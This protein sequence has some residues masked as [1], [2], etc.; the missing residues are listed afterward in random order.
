[1]WGDQLHSDSLQFG[2]KRGCG[3]S[4]ATWLVQ[5]VL[6]HFLR[7]GSK[8]IAVV[9]DCS[10]AFDLAK[11][12]ILFDR[13]LTERKVPAIVVRVLSF[14]YQEQL[15]WVRWGRGCT[16]SSFG[17]TNGTRQGSVASPAF[18]SVYLDPLFSKLREEGVGCH[19]AGVYMG[20]IGYADD[21]ILLATNRTAAQRMLNVC[22]KFAG[23]N[24]INFST[25]PDPVKSKSKAMY[26]TGLKGSVLQKPMPLQLCGQA[27]PWV[28]Q[29]EHLGHALCEDG[30]MA[31]DAREKRAQF[32]DCSAKIRETFSFAHPLEQIAAVEKYC[33]SVYGSNLYDLTSKEANMIFSSWRTGIKISWDTH[34]G[35]R[36]Y[37]LQSVLAPNVTSLRVN[38]LHR[39]RGFFWSLLKSPSPEVQVAVRLGARDIRSTVGANLALL[40]CETGL[41][42]WVASPGQLRAALLEAERVDTPDSDAWRIPF[43]EKLLEEKLSHFYSGNKEE[44]ERVKT[45]IDSLVIN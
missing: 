2:F 7:E 39:F 6:Q 42:P 36:T 12:D 10:K 1:M 17:I 32:I 41:D 40:R 8:P 20:V 19:V 11:F 24:N 29:A 14:S 22:E 21:L 38:L 5:E 16:S 26:V 44:E 18:W 30:M 3:T 23:E 31:Q 45:L 9:L 34:R 25:N 27:L 13:L 35:C 28:A 33:T 15:A 4:T 43:L 37:L